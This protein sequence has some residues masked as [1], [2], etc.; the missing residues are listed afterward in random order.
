MSLSLAAPVKWPRSMSAIAN[1]VYDLSRTRKLSDVVAELEQIQ[2]ET[3]GS[4]SPGRRRLARDGVG[5]FNYMYLAVTNRIA[6]V[7]D[8]EDDAFVQRLAIVFAEY[9]LMAYGA[10]RA[11]QHISKA[12]EPLFERRHERGIS[13]LQ[14]AIAGMNA[15]INNDLAWALVQVWDEFE[16]VP[17]ETEPAHRDFERVNDVLAEVQQE[18]RSML[19]RGFM[20]WLNRALGRI[21][22]RVAGFS[23]KLARN[24]AWRR[25]TDMWGRLDVSREARHEA[26]VGFEC[27]VILEADL[28]FL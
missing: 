9:Y 6:E 11:N 18:V 5:C 16:Q 20:R 23:I 13:P 22:D 8:F 24:Q 26:Q 3:S 28:D 7:G 2:R 17:D 1:A 27:H 4:V 25:G 10:D 14:F 12:W 19:E 21:D 15:H